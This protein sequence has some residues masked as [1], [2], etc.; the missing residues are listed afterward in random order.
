MALFCTSNVR[1]KFLFTFKWS[2]C[3]VAL[4]GVANNLNEKSLKKILMINDCHYM[5]VQYR[6]FD[7]NREKKIPYSYA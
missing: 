5:S 7:S 1:Y 6:M 4:V 2:A 3:E